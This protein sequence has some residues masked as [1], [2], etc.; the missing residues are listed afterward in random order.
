MESKV[1]STK[2]KYKWLYF[3]QKVHSSA[4]RGKEAQGKSTG[5]KQMLKPENAQ[6]KE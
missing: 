1:S 2:N 4:Q 5:S 6:S 3:Y